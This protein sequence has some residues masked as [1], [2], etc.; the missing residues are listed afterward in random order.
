VHG[1][2]P[3]SVRDEGYNNTYF[4]EC[5]GCMKMFDDDDLDGMEQKNDDG[6]TKFVLMCSE[7]IKKENEE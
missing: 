3:Y 4:Q 2:T 1:Y 7:C 5:A 6:T